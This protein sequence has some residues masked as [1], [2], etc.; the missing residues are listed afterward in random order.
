[1]K[2]LIGAVEIPS[3]V[4]LALLGLLLFFVAMG[5][6][7]G[8]IRGGKRASI[9]LVTVIVALSVALLM[10]PVFSKMMLNIKIT[11]GLTAGGLI[12]RELGGNLKEEAPEIVDFIKAC[13]VV[14]ANFIMFFVLY[15]VFKFI[16]W[17]V[18][19]FLAKKFAPKYRKEKGEELSKLEKRDPSR[20][21]KRGRL[22]GLGV[23][24]VTG[25]VFFGFFMIPVTGSMQTLRAAADYTPTF[26]GFNE[27][28]TAELTALKS[29]NDTTKNLIEVYEDIN[30]MNSQLQDSAFGVMT[31]ITGMQ[32]VGGWGV[33]YLTNVK[34]SKHKVNIKSD[35]VDISHTAF[36]V[37]AIGIEI[38]RDGDFIDD[39]I[40]NWEHREYQAIQTMLDRI[41]NLGLVQMAYSYN[42]QAVSALKKDEALDDLFDDIDADK[43]AGYD[44]LTE[45]S[46][47]NSVRS[48]LFNVLS[49]V[50][51][52]FEN[53]G[54]LY[55]GIKDL[56]DNFD[57]PAKLDKSINNLV[58][59][60]GVLSKNN[61][62]VAKELTS[63]FF[64][65]NFVRTMFDPAFSGVYTK[66][67][68]DALNIER[69]DAVIEAG[70]NTNWEDGP[71]SVAAVSANILVNT[72]GILGE[73]SNLMDEQDLSI[74]LTNFDTKKM[75][76]VLWDLT[77][78][79]GI[80]HIIRKAIYVNIADV[81][82]GENGG[83]AIET[84]KG[85]VNHPLGMDHKIDWEDVLAR[86]V[87]DLLNDMAG[88]V[89]LHIWVAPGQHI[90]VAEEIKKAT[91]EIA[92]AIDGDLDIEDPEKLFNVFKE[93]AEINK[94]GE[95]PVIQIDVYDIVPSL[96]AEWNDM[97]EFER[98]MRE[99]VERQYPGEPAK[100]DRFMLLFNFEPRI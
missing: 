25:L 4:M 65:L 40:T 57:E 78:R 98:L 45:M 63:T 36:D 54:A 48:D 76:S 73:M 14:V 42:D 10:T 96:G 39:K 80:G 29:E 6:L 17:I 62:E 64:R 55:Y 15:F 100:V 79:R 85:E 44:L 86:V 5:A 59:K 53:N 19:L 72:I 37:M 2:S 1:M 68:A 33:S 26:G 60:N 47:L 82:L 7:Y 28:S 91:G 81:D 34:T 24:I 56:S 22:A 49:L 88:K 71:D 38:S 46:S 84:I 35:L 27:Y 61:N 92:A 67:I 30:S 75:G 3:P 41:F 20:R 97:D 51:I 8:T 99:E 11:D 31:R 16:S 74:R 50:R 94:P 66:P 9:R 93:L 32:M 13:A 77:N 69:E 43:N 52:I 89:G 58:G 70:E 23:G 18:Y 90:K 83:T 95:P 87:I 12:E 21:I